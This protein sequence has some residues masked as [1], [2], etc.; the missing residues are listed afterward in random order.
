MRADEDEESPTRRQVAILM[1]GGFALAFVGFSGLWMTLNDDSRVPKPLRITSTILLWR[2]C[3]VARRRNV[4]V[5]GA[6]KERDLVAQT[7]GEH[8]PR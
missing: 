3:A 1:F 4:L 5:S 6:Y 8:V 2:R 7:F